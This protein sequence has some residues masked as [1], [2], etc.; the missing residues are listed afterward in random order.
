MEEISQDERKK[1]REEE[2]KKINFLIEKSPEL[3][4]KELSYLK[5]MEGVCFYLC[6]EKRKRIVFLYI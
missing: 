5:K 3:A 2:R 1:I 6:L 4:E